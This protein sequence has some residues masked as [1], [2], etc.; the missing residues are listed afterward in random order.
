MGSL[1][2]MGTGVCLA[3]ILPIALIMTVRT[4]MRRRTWTHTEATVTSVKTKRRNNGETST[5]VHYR[6]VDSSGQER[7]GTDTPWLRAP[8]RNSRIAVMY[9]PERE[10]VSEASSMVWLYVLLVFALALF[11]LGAV[12]IVTGLRA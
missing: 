11:G 9:D 12:L 5:T 7:S 2:L 8:K 10:G 1:N 6:F 3:L 4:W